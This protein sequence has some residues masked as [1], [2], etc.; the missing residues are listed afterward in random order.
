MRVALT[1]A[2]MDVFHQG[3]KN[4]LEK[5]RWEADY[6]VVVIHD[7][8]SCYRIKGKLPIQTAKHRKRNILLTGLADKV[9]ITK[10]IDPADQ[11]VKIINKH[12]E[13][14]FMRG[15]DNKEFPGKWMIDTH[16][17][18]IRYVPYTDGVSSTEIRMQNELR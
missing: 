9:L 5:M 18:P 10:S 12:K 4:I 3:H 8:L 6:V 17:I 2:I 11:F 16:N 1:A 7:D 13:I 15:D 14:V